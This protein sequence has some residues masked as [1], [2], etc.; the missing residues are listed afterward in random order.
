[1]VYDLKVTM[2][3]GHKIATSERSLPVSYALLPCSDRKNARIISVIFSAF[4]RVTVTQKTEK[5]PSGTM[6]TRDAY[7]SLLLW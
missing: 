4:N 7:A 2:V 6:E 5:C 1:V 3:V